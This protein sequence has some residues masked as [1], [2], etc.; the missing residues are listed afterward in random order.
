MLAVSLCLDQLHHLEVL[1]PRL[2][3]LEGR[4]VFVENVV[5]E[6][7]VFGGLCLAGPRIDS[8]LHYLNLTINDYNDLCD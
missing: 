2:R 8:F 4:V 7:C 6:A 1:A 5:K 3:F